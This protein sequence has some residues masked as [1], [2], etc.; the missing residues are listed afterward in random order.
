MSDVM[1]NR[2]KVNAAS[3]NCKSSKERTFYSDCRNNETLIPVVL[4]KWFSE[5]VYGVIQVVDV[6]GWTLL[7]LWKTKVSAWYVVHSV[8]VVL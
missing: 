6:N 4:K 5:N 3:V 7:A 2:W 1:R 8:F